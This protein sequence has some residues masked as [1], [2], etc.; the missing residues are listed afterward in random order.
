[1]EEKNKLEEKIEDKEKAFSRINVKS[2]VMVAVLILPL[3]MEVDGIWLSMGVAEILALFLSLEMLFWK[4]KRYGYW[5]TRGHVRV[6]CKKTD[7]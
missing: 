6:E 2:F 3:W 1:M 7:F 5:Q 4:R